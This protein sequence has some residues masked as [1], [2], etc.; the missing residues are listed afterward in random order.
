LGQTGAWFDVQYTRLNDGFLAASRDITARKQREQDLRESQELLQ[1]VFDTSLISMS[2]LKAVR[3]EGGAVLDFRIVMANKEL[4]RETGRTD[5]EG[6]LYSEE[7]PGI[8]RT[9]LYDLML[10]VLETGEPAGLEYFYP[11][12][13]FHKWYACQFVKMDDGL[14]ATNLDITERKLAE[15]KSREQA[16]FIARVNETL[17]DLMKVTELATG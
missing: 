8:K 9:S 17:P 1:S 11:H 7:Y 4:E 6:K 5:L 10:G 16:H 2:V 3:D 15:E 14:V 13:G 12:E